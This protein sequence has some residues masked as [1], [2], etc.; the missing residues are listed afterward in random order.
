MQRNVF[1]MNCG[2]CLTLEELRFVMSN[3]LRVIKEDIENNINATNTSDASETVATDDIAVDKEPE[4]IPEEIH[5][6]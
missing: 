5:H 1:L 6:K 2:Q 3:D 4:N